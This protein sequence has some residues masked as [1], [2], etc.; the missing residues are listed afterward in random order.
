MFNFFIAIFISLGGLFGL[1]LVLPNVLFNWRGVPFYYN[2]GRL[3]LPLLLLAQFGP[4][5]FGVAWLPPW[6]FPIGLILFTGLIMLY[7]YRAPAAPVEEAPFSNRPKIRADEII[8]RVAL[9]EDLAG[10]GRVFA[11]A[12]Q[13]N[14]DLDFGPNRARNGQLLGELLAIKQHE[15]LVAVLTRTGE[16]VGTLWLDLGDTRVPAITFR[17]TWPV[18]RRYLNW[19][20]AIYLATYGLPST[21]DR[22]GTATTGYVQW[23]GTDPK[24]QGRQIGRYLVERA[25][26]LSRAAGKS[27]LVL[28]T[29]R[30]NERARKLYEGTGFEN[31]TNVTFNPRIKY[32]KPL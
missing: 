27:A 5:L 10:A 31:R 22:R 16:V 11:E 13:R 2:L 8:I 24:W 21:M 28:H 7:F 18:V 14:F 9:P 20:R 32:V 6:V 23:L 15:I 17:N 29:E 12:F 1:A 25:I 4:Y 19:F 26:L 30:Y 3:G